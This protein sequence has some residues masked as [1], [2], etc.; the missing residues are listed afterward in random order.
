ML[1]ITPKN[2]I[3]EFQIELENSTINETSTR[4]IVK[5]GDDSDIV[6]LSLDSNGNVKGEIPLK[7]NWEGKRGNIIIEVI[8]SDVYFS[9]FEQEVIFEDIPK[10]PKATIKE[11]T[12]TSKKSTIKEESKVKINQ[13]IEGKE[14]VKKEV[15][16]KPKPTIQEVRKPKN[17]SSKVDKEIVD[18]MMKFFK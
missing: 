11:I 14:M 12:L 7:E 13:K 5:V 4:L 15:T 6:P 1:K 18:K 16:L 9:P 10:S 17:I 2:N 8:T 3:I